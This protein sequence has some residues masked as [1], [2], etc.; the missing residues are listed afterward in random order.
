MDNK[1]DNEKIKNVIVL[2]VF[3]EKCFIKRV[4]QKRI[5]YRFV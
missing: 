1:Q 2:V 4:M 3:A 5:G